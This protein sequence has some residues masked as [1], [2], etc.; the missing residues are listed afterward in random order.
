MVLPIVR[1]RSL[2]DFHDHTVGLLVHLHDDVGDASDAD[3]AF[4]LGLGFGLEVVHYVGVDPLGQLAEG[5]G[6][7]VGGVHEVELGDHEEPAQTVLGDL[8]VFAFFVEE[9]HYDAV[10]QVV[11]ADVLDYALGLEDLAGFFGAE[12]LLSYY[13]GL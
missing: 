4:G 13:A 2:L 5:D 10:H 6:T 3:A 9:A 12:L 11:V 8:A 7:Q 1:F